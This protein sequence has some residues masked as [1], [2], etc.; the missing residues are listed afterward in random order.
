MW[1]HWDF[2]DLSA[3]W[4]YA[5]IASGGILAMGLHDHGFWYHRYCQLTTKMGVGQC[6]IAENITWIWYDMEY[7]RMDAIYSPRIISAEPS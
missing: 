2:M 1:C 7:D 6:G 3:S 5:A 4:N